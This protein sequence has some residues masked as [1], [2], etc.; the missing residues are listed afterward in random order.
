MGRFR[1]WPRQRTRRES[2]RLLRNGVGGKIVGEL[3]FRVDA[4]EE[5][6]EHVA[7]IL[8]RVFRRDEGPALHRRFD[9]KRPD[10]H[11]GDDAVSQ[12]EAAPAAGF[13]GLHLR[14]QEPVVRDD[15]AQV[16][17]L[18]QVVRA[19]A[20]AEN[21]DR[22]AAGIQRADVAGAVCADGPAADDQEP[23]AGEAARQVRRCTEA[24]EARV[25]GA[26][27]GEGQRG[28]GEEA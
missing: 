28:R 21:G 24:G 4:R 3:T 12:R 15:P 11:A 19:D 25:A 10:G 26:D 7:V 1:G 8:F 16:R 18:L 5:R 14:E 23:G 2:G 13:T 9:H 17:V 6:D 22:G 27:H 20:R